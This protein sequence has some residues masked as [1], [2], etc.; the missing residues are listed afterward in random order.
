MNSYQTKGYSQY[1]ASMGRGSDLPEDTTAALTI[2]K[3]PI[4]AGGYDPGGAYWG[5]PANLYC[6]SDED[7]RTSYQRAASFEAV[8][9]MFPRATWA[10]ATI[11]ASDIEDMLTAYIEAALWSTNDESTEDGGEPFDSNYSSADVDL[12]TLRAMRDDCIRFVEHNGWTFAYLATVTDIDW[13]Q[14]G[15]DFW[16]TRNGH[17]VGF[18]DRDCYA[19]REKDLHEQARRFREVPLY[20]GDDGKIHHE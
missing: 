8:R 18:S 19:G 16:L 12:D 14:V 2:R 7:G 10:P 6:V 13:S 17:G 11:D 9:A 20:L 1:G 4:D 3:V 15:H 5:T